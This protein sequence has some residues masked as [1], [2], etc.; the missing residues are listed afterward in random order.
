MRARSPIRSLVIAC[1]LWAGILSASAGAGLPASF[2]AV[3][4]GD[5]V[6]LESLLREG[7]NPDLRLPDGTTLLMESAKWRDLELVQILLAG[8]ADPNAANGDGATALIWGAGHPEITRSLLERG[9]DPLM[10]S[11]LGNTALAAAVRHPDAAASVRLLMDAEGKTGQASDRRG[12]LARAVRGGNRE[13]FEA[14]VEGSSRED[15]SRALLAAASLGRKDLADRLLALG[16]DPNW[17]DGFTGHA[18]N[19]ALLTGHPAIAVE[20]L[21]AGADLDMPT[22]R[23]QVPPVMLSVYSEFEDESLLDLLASRGARL[24]AVN[25]RGE[26]AQTWARRR[27]HAG[28]A[29]RL[30]AA[31]VIEGVAKRKNVPRRERDW[32]SAGDPAVL[33]GAVERSLSLLQRG[34]DGFLANRENCVSCHHQNLPAVA[35]GWGRERGL[36]VEGAA[37]VRMIEA[38]QASWSEGSRLARVYQMDNPVPVPPQFLG[39]GF[40]GFGALGVEADEIT[41]AMTWYLARIQEVDGHWESGEVDRPPMGIGDILATALAARSLQ[42][43]PPR[44][45][46]QA[47][48]GELARAKAWLAEARPDTLQERAF[49]ALSLSWLGVSAKELQGEAEAMLAAQ[50]EDGGWAQ[51]PTM[52]S[53]AWATGE[54]LTALR[55]ACGVSANEEAYRKGLAFLLS[56]QFE[57]GSWFVASRTWPFQPHFD[58]G[59]PHGR[60][61]WISAP[62]TAWAAMAMLLAIDPVEEATAQPWESSVDAAPEGEDKEAAAKVSAGETGSVDFTRD[63][64]LVLE[65]S[66]TGCHGGESPK[67]GLSLESLEGVLIGGESGTPAVRPGASSGSLLARVATGAV[68]DLEMPPPSKRDRY[69]ALSEEEVH[70]LR[71][72]IDAGAPWPEGVRLNRDN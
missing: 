35:F 19:A 14:L 22:P 26:T 55:A 42:L 47:Y 31:G 58:S 59:F 33:R 11:R 41:E 28:M 2:Q 23:G 25:A 69:P 39:W 64:G 17:A 49:R 29:D 6:L 3:Q 45:R 1:L 13:V 70:R 12:F 63:I 51:L 67:G 8:G 21:K 53:D 5:A 52:E 38:Q 57:D 46:P 61:Q 10:R 15:R 32:R 54:T 60:D 44:G 50:R 9:A 62:A 18:L 27:G 20:L 66:C 43:Y 36:A 65:R 30:A 24:T 16:A 7:S 48:A 34:S 71:M 37:M 4:R 68:E 40:L 56:T 72:W